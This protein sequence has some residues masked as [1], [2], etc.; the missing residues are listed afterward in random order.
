MT[1]DPFTGGLT[2]RYATERKNPVWC[3]T[4]LEAPSSRFLLLNALNPLTVMDADTA[5]LVWLPKDMAQPWINAGCTT[6]L[7]GRHPDGYALWAIDVTEIETSTFDTFGAF[8]ELRSVC[9]LLPSGEAAI[10]AQARSLLGWHARHTFCAVC[11]QPTR[12]REVGSHRTCNN[13]LCAASHFPRTDPVAIM[14]VID[15]PYALL[16]R[17]PHLAQGVYTALAGFIDQGETLEAAVRRE[18]FEEAGIQVGRVAYVQSQPWPWISNLMLGCIAEAASRDIHMDKDELEDARWV[19]VD[20]VRRGL[21][22]SLRPDSQNFRLPTPLA[23]A[24]HIAQ[25]WVT[26]HDSGHPLFYAP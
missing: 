20:D 7:L 21:A 6:V 22:E 14:M 2:H 1:H 12:L 9:T 13:A 25:H 4:T 17:P 8:I 24:H 10:A 23:I 26:T 15:G 3:Q 16:G 5:Q 19:H 18:I 11:G